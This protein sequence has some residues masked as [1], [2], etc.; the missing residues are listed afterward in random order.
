MEV[1]LFAD[2]F[3][4]NF[5]KFFKTKYAFHWLFLY[6]SHCF[7]SHW[8]AR[9]VGSRHQHRWKKRPTEWWKCFSHSEKHPQ[10]QA[11]GRLLSKPCGCVN[12]KSQVLWEKTEAHFWY[13]SPVGSEIPMKKVSHALF[14]KIF[15]HAKLPQFIF[16]QWILICFKK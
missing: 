10:G 1:L 6:H 3:T 14:A 5:F 9:V 8:A 16:L 12:F 13:S 7:L 11:L 2:I 4:W 15:A